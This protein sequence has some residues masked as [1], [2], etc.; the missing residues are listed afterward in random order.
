MKVKDVRELL[1]GR[2]TGEREFIR[3]WEVP[4]MDHK[5]YLSGDA[6]DVVEGKPFVFTSVEYCVG[7][8]IRLMTTFRKNSQLWVT[9]G[10]RTMS[11]Y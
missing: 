2:L 6:A 10:F 8:Q 4:E 11:G 3:D 1:G 5:R 7:F 9:E